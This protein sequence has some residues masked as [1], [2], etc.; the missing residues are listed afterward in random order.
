MKSVAPYFSYL[1]GSSVKIEQGIGT[2]GIFNV[3]SIG[4]AVF[5]AANLFGLAFVFIKKTGVAASTAA[6][7]F[8]LISSRVAARLY[9]IQTASILLVAGLWL[10]FTVNVWLSGG[11]NSVMAGF[12]IAITVMSG[13]LLGER[14]ASIV[15]GLS[16]A[17][18]LGMTLLPTFGYD[19]PHYY[20]IPPWPAFLVQIFWFILVLVP[21]N[22]ALR[23]LRDGLRTARK[24]IAQREKAEKDL[25]ESKTKLETA[26][27]SMTD[28]VFISDGEGNIVEFN[29]AFAT[30][31]KFKS[32]EECARTLAEC[33][34]FLD[35]FME[36][37]EL[38]PLDQWA[39]PRALRG[40]TVMN[41][42]YTLRRKD[43]GETW[44]GGYSFAPIRNQAGEIVGSVVAARNI[45]EKKQAE[46]ALRKS[47]ERLRLAQDA[48]QAG[49]WEWDLRTDENFWS[50]ELWGLYGL[51]PHSCEP[52]YEAWLKTVHPDDKPRT[53][54]AVQEAASRGT[55][56]NAEWRTVNGKEQRWL[57]SRGRPLRDATGQVSRY[58]GIVVDITDRKRAEQL[59]RESEKKHRLLI[60]N[61]H[62][63][64]LVCDPD[65]NIKLCNKVAARIM[66][67]SPDE[68]TGRKSVDPAWN[69]LAED[70]SPMPLEQ[71]PI[72]RIL[73]TGQPLSDVVMGYNQ[74][75]KDRTTWVLANAYP[76]FDERNQLEQLVLT[77]VD[78]TDRR[79]TE[80]ILAESEKKFR[81]LYEEAPVPYQSLDEGWKIIQVNPAWLQIM[82]YPREEVVGRDFS[83]F[84]SPKSQ[85]GLEET[86][87]EF[88]LV[89]HVYGLELEMVCKDGTL[90]D[91][92]LDGRVGLQEDGSFHHTHC[93]FQDIT[94]KKR[95]EE[96]LRE[97]E[98][99]YRAT[100]DNASVGIGL[101]NAEGRFLQVNSTLAQFLGHTPEELHLRTLLDVTHPD[102]VVRS[103]ESHDAMV[104]GKTEVSRLEKRYV[105]KDG[106]IL[107]ADTAVATIRDADG[108]YRATVGVITD[109]TKR[110]KLEETR[111]R[112]S[113]A[114]EQAVETVEIT[115]PQGSIV[116]VNPSF[117]RTTGYLREEAVG[118]NPRLL[119]SGRHDKKF[120]K[121]MW[122][123]ITSGNVWRGQLV[124]KKKDGTLFEEDVCISPVKDNSGKIVNYVAVK[125]DISQEIS[126][127][128]QLSQAQKMEA[129]GT[130]AGGVAHD[131]NNVL[132]IALGYSEIMLDDEEFPERYR[133]DLQ[134]VYESVERGADLVQRLLTFSRKT[135]I[136][137][138][139]LSLNRRVMEVQKMI[140]R[141]I[142]KMIEIRLVLDETLAKTNAD[143]TQMDQILM[144][145]AVN[146]RD[147]MPEGGKLAFETA[148]VEIDEEYAKTHLDV[149]PGSYVLLTVTD[150]G[151]GMDKETLEH[152]F[153]PFYTTKGV[154]EGTGLGL[155]MVHGIVKQ[156]GGH[157]TCYSE[158][159]EGT[160]F[161]IYLPALISHEKE[162]EEKAL[163][164]PR[165]G[166]ETILLVE[167]EEDIRNLG[168]RILERGGYKVITAANGKEALDVYQQQGR[169]IGLVLLDLMMPEMGGEQCLGELL[170]IDPKVKVLIAS[171]FSA[172]GPSKDALQA[173]AKGFVNKPYN[174]RQVLEAVRKVLDSE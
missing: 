38:A 58:L 150:T 78:I 122:D 159:G 20:P 100:F 29:E 104:Q 141:T 112:L 22:I 59:I 98:Q 118:N 26:L 33:P 85:E 143:K 145:L 115:D 169:D 101:T 93:V 174:I 81:L 171:G 61:L 55:E 132:Q 140:E 12:Y 66:G 152:I 86:F 84:L 129:V 135:E 123:T 134:T 106:S 157:I 32:K 116:Y 146:A 67:L 105:R 158:P 17:A 153:E 119:K 60:E 76:A 156:H 48:A 41:A 74:P 90:M 167:D 43:T 30:F 11:V 51:E 72:N 24:E 83:E 172:N 155:A 144:N 69:L 91:V 42:E 125:R 128:R 5:I 103:R 57:M 162:K 99:K 71:Y 87:L 96:A 8:F 21:T 151:S 35:V 3:I 164:M 173:G 109:I 89:G 142:P 56:L 79:R 136:N 14:F 168:S 80:V 92:S 107:W 111:I 7:I 127:Q 54:R 68:I 18:C 52:S 9:G 170:N 16:I 82:G 88:R 34:V 75:G 154:G 161:K 102:D 64:V 97:S 36:T 108:Q 46:E 28:A 15:A 65:T 117:E 160:A 120:Y 49:T 138:Q 110:K 163:P 126:L 25:L 94:Q 149:K 40:E 50:E 31:H 10:T 4:V 13:V 53:E 62:A 77:F 6:L 37:G 1:S 73:S 165:V 139:P 130:L 147:A 2:Y 45:T 63:G 113:A 148:N 19:A 39:V 131:F 124:N 95:T 166:S 121:Q 133:A 27:A 70:G 23:G 47:E 137:P 114:V 44:V